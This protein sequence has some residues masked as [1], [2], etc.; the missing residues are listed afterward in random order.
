VNR[1]SIFIERIIFALEA[2]IDPEL[3]LAPT[4][5]VTPSEGDQS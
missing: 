2:L 4:P 3:P 5:Q 1:F